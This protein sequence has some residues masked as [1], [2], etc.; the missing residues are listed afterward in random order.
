VADPDGNRIEIIQ[1][2]QPYDPLAS[3]ATRLDGLAEA[4]SPERT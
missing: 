3:G 2:L 4:T 1:W